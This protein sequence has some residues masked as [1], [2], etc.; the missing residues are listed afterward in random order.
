MS[1]Q[2]FLVTGGN[3]G[4]GKAIVRQLASAGHTVYLGARQRDAGEQA[5]AELQA[6]GDVRFV[7]IDLNDEAS[8]AAA[9]EQ[10]N[11]D[12]GYLDGLINNAGIITDFGTASTVALGDLRTTFETNLFGTLSVTQQMLP[13]LRAGNHKA[14][15]NL[16]T[17]LGSITQHGDPS[18]PFHGAVPMAYNASKAALNMFTVLLAKEL[19]AEGFRVNSVSPGWIATDLGGQNAPGTAEEGAAIAVKTALEGSDG[20]TGLFLTSGGVIPW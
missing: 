17:G 15:V 8:Q 1:N 19:R 13:L 4:I 9:V 10:I 16:S 12:S 2:V 7:Q 11:A 20:A 3:K 5:A 14:I 18:W 6:A